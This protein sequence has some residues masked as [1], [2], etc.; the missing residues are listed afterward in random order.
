MSTDYY[1]D[2]VGVLE[3]TDK[4]SSHSNSWDYLRKYEIL[5]AN[6]RDKPLNLIEIGVGNGN[7]VKVWKSFFSRATIVGIDI[8]PACARY[9]EE[10]V[11]I[12]IGSQDDPEFL[13][14]IGAAYPPTI[15]IDDG[16]HLAHHIIYSFERMYRSLKSGG[17]YVVEDLAFHFG[18]NAQHWRSFGS[19]SPVDYFGDIIKARL[20]RNVPTGGA[21]WGTEKYVFDNTDSLTVVDGALIFQKRQPKLEIEKAEEF[22]A[23]YL[24]T[25]SCDSAAY[26]RLAHY[27]WKH[28]GATEQAERAARKALDILPDD[29]SATWM[30]AELL[31][32]QARQDEAMAVA[33]L[34]TERASTDDAMWA[35]LGN[36]RA[37]LADYPAAAVAL[38]KAIEI[39]PKHAH[40]FYNLSVI[41]ERDGQAEDALK[42]A[43]VAAKLAAD[44]WQKRVYFKHRDM[45]QAKA[46][47]TG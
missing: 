26:V 14:R 21:N 29:A 41:L 45:M 30:L 42:Y 25:N 43:E 33:L 13:A 3:G 17:F 18:E 10:R 38:L 5:F 2:I 31:I 8:N 40:H 16:S 34:G 4:S 22:A 12:E 23:T 27:F 19:V 36:V 37:Q 15:I 9:A 7:S 47:A 32:A 44:H 46:A 24:A 6:L 1:L 28:W 20:A 11:K 39:N 35:C